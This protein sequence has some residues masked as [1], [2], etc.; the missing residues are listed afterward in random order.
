MPKEMS[1]GNVTCCD[2]PDYI[3]EDHD[4]DYIEDVAYHAQVATV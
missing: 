1:E 3:D 4:P 2:D